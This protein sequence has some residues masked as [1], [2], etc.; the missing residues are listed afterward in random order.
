[1]YDKNGNH[2]PKFDQVVTNTPD[3]IWYKKGKVV[4]AFQHAKEFFKNLEMLFNCTF[5]VKDFFTRHAI[6]AQDCAQAIQESLEL[7]LKPEQGSFNEGDLD[8]FLLRNFDQ[9]FLEYPD[10]PIVKLMKSSFLKDQNS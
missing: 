10:E 2:L 5:V 7:Q 9:V 4:Y 3:K 8:K 1:M 6:L